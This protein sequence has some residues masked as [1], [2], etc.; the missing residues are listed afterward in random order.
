MQPPISSQHKLSNFWQIIILTA[1]GW[2][3]I[4]LFLENYIVDTYQNRYITHSERIKLV[5]Q[6]WY[7]LDSW[8]TYLL[9]CS[10]RKDHYFISQEANDIIWIIIEGFIALVIIH[11]NHISRPTPLFPWLHSSKPCEHIFSK[12]RPVV[13]DFTILDLTYMISKLRVK[14]CEAILCGRRSV[15]PKAWAAGYSHTYFDNKGLD[16][17]TLS[18]FPNDSEIDSISEIA[19]QEADSHIGVSP[20]RLHHSQGV[21]SVPW[22]P[23]IKS[24]FGLDMEDHELDNSDNGLQDSD[25]EDEED[26]RDSDNQELQHILDTEEESPHGWS[27]FRGMGL[28]PR[29]C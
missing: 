18:L 25:K 4:Y 28:Y 1:L 23:S 6:V 21:E 27:H 29:K 14:L 16:L 13:K 24:W 8:K 2:L 7:F 15:N 17:A 10:Y 22:L 11:H 26:I 12:A 5:L 19:V 3:S 20:S 9:M